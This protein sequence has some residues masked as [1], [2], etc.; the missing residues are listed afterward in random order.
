M[1][2]IIANTTIVTCNPQRDILYDAALAMD[3]GRI[4]AIGPTPE[5][6][7]AYPSADRVDGRGRAVFPG[8]INCHTHLL[9]TADRSILEDFGFPTTLRFPTTG[10]GLLNDD[11]RNVFALLAAI[12]AIRSGTTTMLEISDR[13]PQYAQSLVIPAC[14]S[15]SPKIS[16]MP[17][18]RA[19]AR[20]DSTSRPPSSKPDSAAARN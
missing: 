20:A 18:T 19:F 11:E 14:A 13:I 9:A 15:S 16:T 17:T 7:A 12:E 4:V 6:E 2:T 5:I 10:R 3:D 1:H 8:L